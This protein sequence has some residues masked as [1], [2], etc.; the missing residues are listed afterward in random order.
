MD[1]RPLH[2][3]GIA[4]SLRRASFNRGLIRA[5]VQVAPAYL[6]VTTQELRDLPMFDADVEALGDSGPV[7]AVNRAI[8]EADA[9]LAAWTRRLSLG[10]RLAS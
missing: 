1:P 3:L 9:A 2:I 10:E 7:A 8:A 5:A 6:T 4:G